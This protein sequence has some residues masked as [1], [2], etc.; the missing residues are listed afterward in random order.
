MIHTETTPRYNSENHIFY[1][2]FH[3]SKLSILNLL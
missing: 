2:L 1:P 3:V